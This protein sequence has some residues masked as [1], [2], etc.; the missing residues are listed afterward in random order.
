MIC[1]KTFF[2]YSHHPNIVRFFGVVI[3]EGQA[4]IGFVMEYMSDGTVY[5][6]EFN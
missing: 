1:L 3:G 6:S 2:Q 5:D 4:H